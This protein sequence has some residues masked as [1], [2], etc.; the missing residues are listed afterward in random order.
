M[1]TYSSCYKNRS[2]SIPKAPKCVFTI[3]LGTVSMNRCYGEPFH[4]QEI[5]KL[6][7]STFCFHKHQSQVGGIKS[8]C[9]NQ[10][11]LLNTRCHVYNLNFYFG[12]K[13]INKSLSKCVPAAFKRSKR[14]D[15]FSC[16][17]TQRIFWVMFSEVDP[18]RPTAKKM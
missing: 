13:W 2:A 4:V 3:S 15:R 9:Q 16:S 5:R 10:N 1:Q 11:I 18:T 6:V 14:N 7:N 17:S 8:L 12:I